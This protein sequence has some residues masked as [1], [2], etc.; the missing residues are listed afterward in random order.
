VNSTDELRNVA[1]AYAQHN[2]IRIARF[3]GDGNDGAVWESSRLTAIK[4]LYRLDSFQREKNCYDRLNREQIESICGFAIP[5]LID[6]DE[7]RRVIEM[8]IVF[9]PC[10]IDFAK[11]YVDRPPDFSE[12]A[13]LDWESEVRSMFGE[14][15]PI[16]EQILLE[17]RL[18]GIHYFDARPANIRFLETPGG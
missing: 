18:I 9:P 4:V 17:L 2:G 6:V 3:L 5:Q 8:T 10:V 14:R 7:T 15:Y 16:V 1:E 12:E 11:S 13:M